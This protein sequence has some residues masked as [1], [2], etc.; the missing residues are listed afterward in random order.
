MAYAELP[1][2]AS[3]CFT[4]RLHEH[5]YG[6]IYNRIVLYTGTP[7]VKHDD[8]VQP[9]TFLTTLSKVE[10]FKNA[11]GSIED[12]GISARELSPILNRVTKIVPGLA[13]K[14]SLVLFQF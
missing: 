9:C 10:R 3:V 11:G 4:P 1:R 13:S 6:I 7:S 8:D 12:L 14:Q 2:Y 5:A